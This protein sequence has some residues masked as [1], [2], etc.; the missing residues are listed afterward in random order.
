ML[1]AMVK[2]TRRTYVWRPVGRPIRILMSGG[3]LTLAALAAFFREAHL[4]V[5]VTVVMV[6]L[7]GAVAFWNSC[8]YLCASQQSVRLGLSPLWFVAFPSSEVVA[9][10]SISVRPL[11]KEWGNRG[12]PTG[13]DGLFLDVGFSDR[14]V[15]LDLRDGR[16]YSIGTGNEDVDLSTLE[17]QLGLEVET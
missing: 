5:V 12:R 7:I 4:A 15:R 1:S 16:S 2:R 14:A 9:V 13:P 10:R 6:C 8:A 11:G 3:L 17:R